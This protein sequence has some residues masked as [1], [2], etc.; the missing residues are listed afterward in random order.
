MR[1]T[2]LFDKV[3]LDTSASPN[4]YPRGYKLEVSDNGIN[5]NTVGIGTGRS[6]ET[7]IS[8]SAQNARYIRIEQTGFAD[9][10]W[11]SIHEVEVFAAENNETNDLSSGGGQFSPMAHILALFALVPLRLRRRMI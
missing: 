6:A 11:W 1:S 4:D 7:T 9:G 8:F 3:V 10:T 2:Q 5:W